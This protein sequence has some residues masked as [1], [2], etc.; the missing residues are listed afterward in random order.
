MGLLIGSGSVIVVDLLFYVPP[1]V[2]VCVV[3]GSVLVFI[4]SSLISVILIS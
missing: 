1:I 3:G 4:T 2:C